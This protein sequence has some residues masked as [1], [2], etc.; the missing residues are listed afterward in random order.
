MIELAPHVGDVCLSLA[1]IESMREQVYTDS[2][3]IA[4]IC[5][6]AG[7]LLSEFYSWLRKHYGEPVE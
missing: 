3:N 6:V 4:I 2:R 1:Q 7:F 5:F